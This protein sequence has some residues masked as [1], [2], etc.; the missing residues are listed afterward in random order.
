LI[1]IFKE[2]GNLEDF[3]S[4][5]EDEKDLLDPMQDSLV[6]ELI[7][8]PIGVN[9]K[10]SSDEIVKYLDNVKKLSNEWKMKPNSLRSLSK[11]TNNS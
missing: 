6:N 2:E 1:D 8:L 11:I 3:F 4:A 7:H 9:G 5:D 10:Y